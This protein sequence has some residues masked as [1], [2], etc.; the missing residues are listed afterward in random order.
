M[1]LRRL[2]ELVFLV[3]IVLWLSPLLVAC[4]LSGRRVF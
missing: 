3:V 4:W 2:K 1:A